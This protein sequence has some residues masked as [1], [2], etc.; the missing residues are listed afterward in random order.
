MKTVQELPNLELVQFMEACDDNM[1]NHNDD[2]SYED[3]DMEEFTEDSPVS[4][5]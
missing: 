3:Q 4:L 1:L 2:D 5:T